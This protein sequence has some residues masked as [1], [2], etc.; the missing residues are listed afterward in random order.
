MIY[1]SGGGFPPPPAPPG[2]GHNGEHRSMSHEIAKTADGRDAI[3]YSGEVPWHGLGQSKPAG[4]RWSIQRWTEESG[5]DFEIKEAPVLFDAGTPEAPDVRAFP[6]RKALYRADNHLGLGVLS[7]GYKLVQPREVMEF[8]TDLVEGAGFEMETAGVL[9]AGRQYWGLARVL[10][11]A[12]ILDDRDRVGGF[13]L[14]ST[15]CDGTRATQARWTTV[16]VVCNNTLTLAVN[17]DSHFS[18]NH[19]A[20]FDPAEAKRTLGIA[21]DEARE[22]FGRSMDTLRTLASFKVSPADAVQ[23]TMK[24]FGIQGADPED[25][26][27]KKTVASDAFRNIT[28]TAA[29]GQGLVGADLDGGAGTAWGWLNAVTQRAD[30]GSSYRKG[31]FA[32]D[33]RMQRTM[34]GEGEAMKN[35]AMGIA[36]DAA[37]LGKKKRDDNKADL[38]AILGLDALVPA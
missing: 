11:D 38:N 28:I 19:S 24:L 25:E 5:T 3:A 15:S 20:K 9:F 37:G 34:F 4:E 17:G 36:L 30:H 13:L 16:R 31:D 10:A 7:E 18:L 22:A 26:R 23:M 21:G 32:A 35:R 27:F 33:R 1:S 29:T 8:F 12:K 6:G 14:L 2:D